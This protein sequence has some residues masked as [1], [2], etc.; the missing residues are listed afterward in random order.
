[1]NG[2][3]NASVSAGSSHF[4]ASVTCRPH[5]I[6]PSGAAATGE[7]RATRS[8]SET[9]SLDLMS[10]SRRP[11]PTAVG[12]SASRQWLTDGADAT[13]TVVMALLKPLTRDE[14]G[15]ELLPLWD[16]CE[17]AYPDFRHLWATMAHS[18]IVF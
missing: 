7:V 17:R 16:A 5:V 12:P 14:I 1:M 6:V 11:D 8:R 18:P 13:R 15:A 4:A 9:A 2:L 3:M 10:A